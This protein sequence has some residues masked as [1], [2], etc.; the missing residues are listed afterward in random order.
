MVAS[1]PT[2]NQPVTVKVEASKSGAW[3]VPP[4]VV[5]WTPTA[6]RTLTLAVKVWPDWTFPSRDWLA[7]TMNWLPLAS[8]ATRA[9]FSTV[10]M[11]LLLM[12]YWVTVPE[13]V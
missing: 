5:L 9:A 4:P 10:A 1:A 6:P 7:S 8:T 3:P 13:M 2:A 12:S 11:V